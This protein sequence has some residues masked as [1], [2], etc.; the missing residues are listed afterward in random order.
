MAGQS[1]SNREPPRKKYVR[2]VGPRLRVLLLVIIGCVAIL[3]ANS[4][5]LAAITFLEWVKADSNHTYQNWFYMVMFGFH[6]VLGLLL[7]LPVII[8]GLIHIK[9]AHSRPNRRAVKVGYLL[10]GTALVV[11]V[12]GL[13]LTRADVFQFKNLG[14]KDPRLRGMAYW[15]HVIAPLAAA[16]LYVLHRL[17]GPRIKWRAGVRW[18]AAVAAS[19]GAMVLLH[20]VHPRTNQAGSAEGRKYFEP[21]LAQTATGKFIPARTLMMDDYCLKCH[22]DAYKGWFHSA[23]HF[24]SFNNQPY[25]FSVR[26]TRRV[27][28]QRDG[29]VKAARWCA[30]CHDVVPFFSGAF[31]D[32]RFDD[33]NHPTAQ[34]GITCT[35]C[36]AITHV[37]STK[38]NADYTIDE[39][40]HYPF[41]YSS[42][43][44]LQYINQQLV[45]AKPEFH[46]KTFLKPFMRTAEFCSTCHKVS[47]PGEL[48]KYKEFLRGQNHY[49]TYLLS[50]VSGHGARS[51]YY[52]ATA[53]QN[54]AGCH[55][56]LQASQDFGA[57]FFNATNQSKRY[58]HSHLFPAANTGIAHLR[59]EPAVVAAH[60]AFLT[61]C[62]RVDIFGVKDGGTIDGALTAPLRPTL[63]KLRPG[64]RYLLEVV[65]RTLTVGHPFSQGTTDSNEIWV[66]AKVTSGGKIIG[67]SGG[68]GAFS[69]VDPW[70]HFVNVY[71]L[72]RYGNRIDR[73]N[74]QDIF[75]PLY[76]HQIPPGAGQVVHYECAVPAEQTEPLEFEVKL[77]Y[78]K[79]DTTYLNYV[80]ATNYSKNAP[81]T[82]TNDLPIV[83]IASDRVVFPVGGSLEFQVSNKTG[84]ELQISN[85]KSEIP[86]W[87]RWNDYGIGLLLE[88]NTGAEKGELIQAAQAFEQVEK[89]GRADGP[90]NL[91]R[92][93]FKEGR[94]DDAIGALGRAAN[95]EPAAPRWTLAWFTGLVNKQN[96][97]LDEAIKNFRSILEDRYP[98]LERRG[99][100]FSKDYEVLNELG[101]AY[102]ERAKAERADP[103][104]QKEFLK[105][106]VQA[107]Q[108]TLALDSENLTA[109]YTLALIY[110]QLGDDPRAAYHRREHEKYLPDYNAQDRAITIARRADPA[111]DHAAQATVIYPLQRL[112]AADGGK[113]EI[114][115]PKSE[116]NPKLEARR[117]P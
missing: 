3:A 100:D 62:V 61:N 8:F 17:A 107:F 75:T 97:L 94:L 79:F 108:K 93:Y 49:D 104:R 45:K 113:S 15:A 43:S 47:I 103:A 16:W 69:E 36:H 116:R 31:D 26:E 44:L 2:A 13:L 22:Q 1:D 115:N 92:V 96:G 60:E 63:P 95:C 40:I 32:P 52:P 109:H 39:P 27:A 83:T 37:N 10:F 51:F 57:N 91:A 65:L 50:G 23:H 41:A 105:L 54:C 81:F 90:L 42:N 33:V 88:G 86:G 111:A 21:S 25:L 6:L 71:M 66:D 74:P 38:G 34:A 59:G 53:V 19:V 12:T 20:S 106:A 5:Y 29:N 80:F 35:S 70:A 76:N 7:V 48:N 101:Q 14:L 24:S 110:T 11:L 78:R 46:K 87:Q 9:N 56:P 28:L 84:S 98:E 64:R 30:G 58:I 114:R 102:F 99:F 72:D 112:G 55:M 85:L 18:G 77:Q 4:L 117:R 82:V 89:L 73:R 67:R 68:L